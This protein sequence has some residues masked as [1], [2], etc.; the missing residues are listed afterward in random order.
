VLAFLAVYTGT[1]PLWYR[2]LP[3]PYA[4]RLGIALK[5][6][7]LMVAALPLV[8][9][10]GVSGV[11]FLQLGNTGSLILWS[12]VAAFSATMFAYAC[13]DL[14]RGIGWSSFPCPSPD[15]FTDLAQRA[16]ET[17][18]DEAA[19]LGHDFIGT[20]HLLLGVISCDS[21]LLLDLFRKWEVDADI[22]R[23]E[24]EKV[25]VSGFARKSARDL[26]YTPRAL[27]AL[28]LAMQETQTMNHSFITPEHILLGLLLEKEGLAGVV[29]RKLGIKADRA[30]QDIL[31]GMG[32]GGDDS[33]QPVLA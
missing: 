1:L 12:G 33:L 25:V 17:A 22:I 9:L 15:R 24:I 28:T 29:L 10:L 3:S 20:E 26:P 5:T 27:R 21:G 19:R 14:E 23:S 11:R 13:L 8:A 4:K 7:T 2:S 30:R 6:A 32:P 16:T 18:H 31:H